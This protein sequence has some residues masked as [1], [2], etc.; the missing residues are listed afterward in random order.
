[1]QADGLEE[2]SYNDCVPE[3]AESIRDRMKWVWTEDIDDAY[4]KAKVVLSLA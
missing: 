2:K 4:D 1:M 3:V